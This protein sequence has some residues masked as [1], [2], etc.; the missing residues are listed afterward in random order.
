M[1]N[2]IFLIIGDIF[3][4]LVFILNSFFGFIGY[5]GGILG[6]NSSISWLLFDIVLFLVIIVL[7]LRIINQFFEK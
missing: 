4:I 7:S 1:D 2:K 5:S 6:N 3:V